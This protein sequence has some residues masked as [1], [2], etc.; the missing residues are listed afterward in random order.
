MDMDLHEYPRPANDTGIG[1]HWSA[2]Y[3]AAIGLN[4]IRDLWIPELQAL[5][6]KWVKIFNH[7]GAQDFAGLLLSEGLMPIVRIY[8]PHPNPGRLG[9]RELVTIDEFVRLGVRYFEFNNE[10][11]QDAEWKG[12]R[13]PVNGID[14]VTE[15]AIADMEAIM[16]RGG[17]PA[18][19]VVSNGSNWDLVGKIV[20]HGRK[21]L[22]EGPVWQPIHNYSRNRP[23]DYPYDTG[24]QEGT[25]YT[26]RFYQLIANEQFA[27]D[28][29]HGRS[30]IEIDMLRRENAN[31][32]ASIHDD[33]ACWLAYEFYNARIVRHLGR[34]IPILSTENGYLVG[35][36]TDPRYPSTTP[37]LHMAQTLEA[38][39]VMMGA[40]QRY[41]VAPE[42]YFCTAF[43]LIANEQLGSSSVWWEGQAWYSRNWMG[44]VL[45]IVKALR[46]EPKRLR[47]QFAEQSVERITVH[48]TVLN[49]SDASSGVERSRP[50]IVLDKKGEEHGRT[51]LD[52]ANRYR[53]PDLLPG[54]YTV[55]VDGTDLIEALTLHPGDGEKLLNLDMRSLQLASGKSTLSGI[56][57]GGAEAVVMLVR[58][59]DGEEWVTM[60][61]ADGSFRFVDLPPGMYSARVHP[62]GSQEMGIIIDGEHDVEIELAVWGWGYTV[63]YDAQN[64]DPN[65]IEPLVE[66][67][68]IETG[69]A[70]GLEEDAQEEVE[71]V[72]GESAVVP[73][74]SAN[75]DIPTLSSR[76][77][78]I[79]CSVEGHKNVRVYAKSADWQ[80]PVVETGSAPQYGEFA[81]VIDLLS[82]RTASRDQI[83]AVVAEGVVD[84]NGQ[85]VSLE[86]TVT[87]IPGHRPTVRF[88]YQETHQTTLAQRSQIRGKVV[89]RSTSPEKLFVALFGNQAQMERTEV[90]EAGHFMFDNLGPGSYSVVLEGFESTVFSSDIALDGT[91]EV[92]IELSLPIDQLM[93]PT[94]HGDNSVIAALVPM[95]VGKA[96]YLLDEAGNEQT[97]IIGPDERVF[98]DQLPAGCYTLRADG[99]FMETGLSVDGDNGLEVYFSPLISEWQSEVNVAGSMPGFSA[100][101]AEVRG[102][103]GHTVFMTKEDQTTQEALTGSRPDLGE[104]ALEF[105]PLEPG[106]YIVEPKGLEVYAEVELT[107]LE[108]VWVSFWEKMIPSNP[109]AVLPLKLGDRAAAADLAPSFENGQLDSTSFPPSDITQS[110]A[111]PDYAVQHIHTEPNEPQSSENNAEMN[112][113][114]ASSYFMD[115]DGSPRTD[116]SVQSVNL[117]S[118][119]FVDGELPAPSSKQKAVSEYLFIEEPTDESLAQTI[120]SLIAVLRYVAANQPEIGSNLEAARNAERVVI[121]GQ[122]S[123]TALDLLSAA[124]VD[125]T[126]ASNSLIEAFRL[127]EK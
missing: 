16:E 117:P 70:T 119:D 44:G 15:D 103:S 107:G 23:L 123:Q 61:R 36:S 118:K 27:F 124:G 24:N 88:V 4:R 64:Q 76:C 38:C 72:D 34:S 120:E 102:R 3:A 2:G 12:G 100:I 17:M 26:E 63:R 125:V 71:Q 32:G 8:R 113:F 50:H 91:N 9:V 87:M 81:C 68:D 116:D 73:D 126:Q 40:S 74:L 89:G 77:T 93:V 86:A 33:H 65:R 55:R 66:F 39:R 46:A 5:G 20:E 110:K 37:E 122:V 82:H 41:Q 47:P 108:A 84:E 22:F 59:D 14:L 10:P 31:P 79:R 111:H 90:N 42:Y 95:A 51:E 35:E 18:L 53:F 83:Y 105:S 52:E 98:F 67:V 19:P 94:T 92:N 56:V 21:D 115:Y 49:L 85:P 114:D 25:P 121:M 11:D 80:S 58:A 6:V 43:T 78:V 57:R 28:P 101:R 30:L 7:D 99:G 45:P 62:N 69:L 75:H 29:W 109:N 13:V 48:G 127:V 60:A 96:A 1:I 104:F 106:R 112:Q 54:I 97:H